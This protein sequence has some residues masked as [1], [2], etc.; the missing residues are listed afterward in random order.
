MVRIDKS[1]VLVPLILTA[2]GRGGLATKI[3]ISE[4][5]AGGS[6]FRFKDI[7]RHTSVKS[8][9]R[10]LQNGKCCFCE[11]YIAHVSH[12]DV[13]HFRPKGGFQTDEKQ[14]LQ[15]PGYYWLAYDFDNL[16][17]C[18]QICNQVYKRNYFP[19][20]DEKKRTRSHTQDYREEDSLIIHP[21]F[22]D[23]AQHLTFVG[24]VIKPVN[25]SKKGLE[26]I[27]RTGLDREEL[28]DDRF[29]YLKTLRVL[30]DVA[31]SGGPQSLAARQHFH[32]ISQATAIYS[33]MVRANFPDLIHKP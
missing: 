21:E 6:T 11:D 25:G 7:Y 14:P 18:C 9:L 22:D 24:E 8:V 2:K 15:I 4:A 3:L 1:S 19:L 32:E 10:E 20:S 13:E 16:F 17:Y 31:R 23:P 30:A 12:G 26:T 33:A 5:E 28:E 27:R 29:V